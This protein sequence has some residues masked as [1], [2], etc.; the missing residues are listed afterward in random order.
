MLEMGE[1]AIRSMLSDTSYLGTPMA[2]QTDDLNLTVALKDVD[3][4]V[5]SVV[6]HEAGANG[7]YSITGQAAGHSVEGLPKGVYIVKKG[8]KARKVTVK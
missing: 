8:G 1:P 5:V 3:E 4:G 2:D 7:V 6:A